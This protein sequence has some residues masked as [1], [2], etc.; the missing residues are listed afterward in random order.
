MNADYFIS[1]LN[2]EK[3]PEGGF[4]REL[5]R[6]DA[7]LATSIYFLLRSGEV[8]KFHRL[9]SD[10]IWYFH[11]G[12]SLT[13]HIIDAGGALK[14]VKLGADPEAGE[15]PQVI[16]PGGCIFGATVNRE[17]SYTLVGCMVS[18]GFE[19]AGFELL[20]RDRL[21]KDYPQ[22]ENIIMLLT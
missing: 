18:P 19:F 12:T 7:N 21:L 6:Q 10:E 9:K 3:H 13:V 16:V 20:S 2:L 11:A 15:Q 8:S 5:Y 4:Y 14:A 22:H 1:R 17:D